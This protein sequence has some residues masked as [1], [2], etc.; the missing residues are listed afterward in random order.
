MI[1]EPFTRPPD[2]VVGVPGSK[3]ITN[4]A[5]VCAAL[6]D[7]DSTLHGALV[8]DD[9][10]AMS[11]CLRA[12]GIAVEW[13]GTEA[14]VSGCGGR[15][16]NDEARLD[17]CLSGTTARFLLPVLALGRGP[18]VLDGGAP[19]QRR[20]MAPLAAAVRALGATVD[21]DALPLTVRGPAAGGHVEIPG[22]VTSQFVSALLLVRPCLPDGLVLHMSSPLVA[23]PYVALTE[24][25]MAD[26]DA[27]NGYRGRDYDVEPDASAASYFFAIAAITG[28][29]VTVDLAYDSRQ[30]DARFVHV[31]EDMGAAVTEG[32]RVVGTGRLAGGTFDLRDMPDMAPTLAVVGVFADSPVTVTGVGFIRGHES[33]RIAAVVAELR[34]CGIEADEHDDGFTVVPGT[35]V[36]ARVETYDDHR[37]AM[38]F[39]VLGA[40]AAGIELVDAGCVAKTFPHFF[41]VL[42]TLR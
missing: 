25:V 33:D 15:L 28:G 11:E 13:S 42:D 20:P 41:E 18:Y 34:R 30:A 8:A 38:S 10:H 32:T 24:A 36:R 39:A 14:R 5:L 12:L 3:S 40:C 26:F 9:T 16:P 19:L 23:R 29:S 6:A 1:V 22:D 27:R 35:P 17:A 21:G 37:M 4:R 2:A 31:L 7:G